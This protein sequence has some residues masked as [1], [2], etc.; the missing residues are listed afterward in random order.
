MKENLHILLA[1]KTPSSFGAFARTLEADQRLVI[2]H[3]ES[4]EGS[5]RTIK[6]QAIDIV[7]HQAAGDTDS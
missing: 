5:L 2:T 4:A 3:A 6:K 1:G 7:A